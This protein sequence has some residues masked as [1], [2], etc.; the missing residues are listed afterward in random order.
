[1]LGLYL[2]VPFCQAICGYCHFN[3]GLHDEALK[4]EYVRALAG[5]IADAGD[6]RAV[7]TVF[8]GGGTPSLLS[9]ADVRFLLETCRRAYAVAPE[10]EITL[11]TNPETATD[12][13]LNGFLEAGVNRISFGVQS[14]DDDELRRLGRIHTASRAAIALRA[15]R[16]SGYANISLDL[17]LWLPGQSRDS[18]RRTVDAA[19][20]LDPDHVS[21][22]L[23]ELYPNSPL[24]EAMARAPEAAGHEWAQVAEDEAAEM[25]LE[26][27]ERFDAAGYVQYEIA[28]VARPGHHS[29]HNVKYWQAGAWR[30]FGCGAHSTLDGLRWF[31]VASTREYIDRVTGGSSV[32]RGLQRLDP[33][34]RVEE[35][36]FMGLRLVA[37][38]DRKVFRARYGVD[39]WERY[40]NSLEPFVREGLMWQAG[41]GFGLQR[42]GMLVANDILSTFV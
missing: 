21:L 5:E 33:G 25:Y 35:A 17:M 14:F 7:D 19:I 2:H 15:A 42:R 37:G 29:R 41:A 32:R 36:L 31:N 8:F 38:I 34:A 24:K 16:A 3:R 10:T 11:E 23:L 1:V 6:G 12:D 18:W 39:P 13:R 28:N 26:G 40:G 27:L 22:Y 20:G 4:T 30:G 9:P